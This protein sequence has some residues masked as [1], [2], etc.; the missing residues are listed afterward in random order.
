MRPNL[1]LYSKKTPVV[2]EKDST[3]LH[4]QNGFILTEKWMNA[5][6]KCMCVQGSIKITYSK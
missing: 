1:I 6:I 4:V 5:W 2:F 3:V